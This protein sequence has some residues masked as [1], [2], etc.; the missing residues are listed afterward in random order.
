MFPPELAQPGTGHALSDVRW[1][2]GP[3]YFDL[4]G[5]DSAVA[6]IRY[7]VWSAD[8]HTRTLDELVKR[9]GSFDRDVGIEMALDG[10]LNNLSSAFDA[11][12]AF[13]IRAT[14]DARDI[15][16]DDR[17][18]GFRY[19]WERCR[20]MLTRA[21]VANDVVW[22]LVIDVDTAIEGES[23]PEPIGWLA[24]LRRLR[25]RVAHQEG[26]ARHHGDD[27]VIGVIAHGQTTDAR[28]YLKV[29][30][31]RIFDLTEQMIETAF[32]IGAHAVRSS[33]NR[34]CWDPP[35]SR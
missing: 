24:R 9:R 8:W 28:A 11:A 34:A 20:A 15:D 12:L 26:L 22:R 17:L 5:S 31:D 16:V 13:L 2:A 18:P 25:N 29:A 10:A 30:C 3:H 23:L 4:T 27:G 19:S 33:W 35:E 14:E 32:S 21:D 7:R 6:W 1:P